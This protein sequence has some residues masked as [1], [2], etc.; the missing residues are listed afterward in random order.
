LITFGEGLA[1]SNLL[2]NRL[3]I[4]ARSANIELTSAEVRDLVEETRRLR[5]GLGPTPVAFVTERPVLYGMI[6]M[7]QI[8]ALDIHPGFCVFRN[9]EEAER[10]VRS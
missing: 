3:L 2:N 9:Y 1:Q 7:Y 4:D 5:N 6:R 8:L 10:W